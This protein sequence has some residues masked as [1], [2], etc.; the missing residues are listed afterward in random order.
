LTAHQLSKR[1]G[2][3]WCENAGDRVLISGEAK[4]YLEGFIELNF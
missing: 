3:L 2:T 1:K 4:T